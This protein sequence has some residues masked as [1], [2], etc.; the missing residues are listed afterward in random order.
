MGAETIVALSK[1]LRKKFG[2]HFKAPKLLLDMAEKGET[3]YQRF[4][5]Y[6][7]GATKEAA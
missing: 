5:P 4:D 2:D 7:K 6:A 3:F 1:K